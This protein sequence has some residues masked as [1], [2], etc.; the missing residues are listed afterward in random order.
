ME[1]KAVGL[2][3]VAL[4]SASFSAQEDVY[5]DEYVSVVM[6]STDDDRVSESSTSE[7]STSQS[8]T[9]SSLEV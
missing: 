5:Y 8:I 9:S 4:L 2:L 6:A 1:W 3:F 7:E